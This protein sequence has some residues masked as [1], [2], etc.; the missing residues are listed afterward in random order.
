MFIIELFNIFFDLIF[1]FSNIIIST[2]RDTSDDIYVWIDICQKE[3]YKEQSMLISADVA[4]EY[5]AIGKMNNIIADTV[6]EI[7]SEKDPMR[8]K[9]LEA[10]ISTLNN[11]IIQREAR[12]NQ[13]EL[14]L[15][16]AE[17]YARA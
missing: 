16:N 5:S 3:M 1:N 15:N 11:M 4:A 6:K 14:A 12:L 17:K 10:R 8:I 9:L 7:K 13:M 2:I